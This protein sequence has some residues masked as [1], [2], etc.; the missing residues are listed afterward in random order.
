MRW[1]LVVRDGD[2]QAAAVAQPLH[3]LHDALAK[4]SLAHD[5]GAVVVV[6]RCREDLAGAGGGMVH[7]QH[8]RQGRVIGV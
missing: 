7:Q 3:R 1:R 4:R 5:G 6:Q 2:R 8:H